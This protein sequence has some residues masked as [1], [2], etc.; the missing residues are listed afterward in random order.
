[1]A[2]YESQI[3]RIFSSKMEIKQFVFFVVAFDP[4]KI[5]T[6]LAPQNDCQHLIFVKDYYVVGKK[7]D[8]K[9]SLNGKTQRLSLLNR[10]GVYFRYFSFVPQ[11]F[12]SQNPISDFPAQY[13][14]RLASFLSS[15]FC[16]QSRYLSVFGPPT[17]GNLDDI[18]QTQNRRGFFL[19]NEKQNGK[20]FSIPKYGKIFIFEI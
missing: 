5:Q 3:F 19:S 7:N 17:H 13:S 15:P 11:L 12:C 14:G 1:M 8:Q 4:I 6:C 2:I 20:I 18:Y 10:I 9:W 16:G